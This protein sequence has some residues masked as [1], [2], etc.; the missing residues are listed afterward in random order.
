MPDESLHSF[1]FRVLFRTGNFDF[2]TVVK[3]GGWLQN[4]MIPPSTRDLFKLFDNKKLIKVFEASTVHSSAGCLFSVHFEHLFPLE[5]ARTWHKDGRV[6]SFRE[7]FY[8]KLGSKAKGKSIEIRFCLQCMQA[9]I[10][11][12]GFAYFKSQWL[13]QT[14]CNVHSQALSA[15][16]NTLSF[17]NIV[18]VVKLLLRGQSSLLINSWLNVEVDPL[19]RFRLQTSVIKLAPCMV[20]KLF[21]YLFVNC[22]AYPEGYYDLVNT[23]PLT[24]DMTLTLAVARYRL[25]EDLAV[26]FRLYYEAF[27]EC[28]YDIAMYFLS[29]NAELIRTTFSDDVVTDYKRWLLK[30]SDISCTD[31][32]IKKRMTEYQ[33]PSSLY[34]PAKIETHFQFASSW[35]CDQYIKDAIWL[36][37][38]P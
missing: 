11:N 17:S 16:D 18:K 5:K 24:G 37:R 9:S 32:S 4:P 25:Y 7:A 36:S 22:R 35:S 30:R 6:P 27:L 21:D 31:C 12:H 29:K 15:I 14:T 1:I 8:P 13:Y 23:G 26:R 20:E 28:N 19:D 10:S 38:K 33:C 34:I 3:K 2:S